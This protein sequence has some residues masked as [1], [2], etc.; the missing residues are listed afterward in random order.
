MSFKKIAVWVML[1]CSSFTGYKANVKDLVNY[2]FISTENKVTHVGHF[3]QNNKFQ[4]TIFPEKWI[5][6]WSLPTIRG[7]YQVIN[8]TVNFIF[9]DS[10]CESFIFVSNHKLSSTSDHHFTFS[11]YKL[12]KRKVIKNNF[13]N[14][15]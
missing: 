7:E 9:N 15:E 1:L 5:S 3:E 8:D 4:I 11:E 10:V 2:S 12:K 14:F 6:C 13:T